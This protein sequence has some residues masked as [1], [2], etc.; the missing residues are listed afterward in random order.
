MP[1]LWGVEAFQEEYGVTASDTVAFA[2]LDDAEAVVQGYVTT[3]HWSDAILSS[4]VDPLAS[5]KI[6]RAVGDLATV[7]LRQRNLLAPVAESYSENYSGNVSYSLS[8]GGTKLSESMT[9]SAILARLSAYADATTL[10]N[11]FSPNTAWGTGRWTNLGIVEVDI[12]QD[13]EA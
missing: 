13:E 4:P 12:T 9:E 7:Y 6:R 10:A 1:D 8:S 5:R 3:A 2:V 11:G